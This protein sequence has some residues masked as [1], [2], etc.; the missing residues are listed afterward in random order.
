MP[1]GSLNQILAFS[2]P[3]NGSF[4]SATFVISCR[5]SGSKKKLLTLLSL[6]TYSP[7]AAPRISPSPVA[8]HRTTRALASNLSASAIPLH[9]AVS[10]SPASASATPKIAPPRLVDL[11]GYSLLLLAERSPPSFGFPAATAPAWPPITSARRHPTLDAPAPRFG[12]RLPVQRMS[13]PRRHRRYHPRHPHHHPL[14]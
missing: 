2:T 14:L 11:G 12:R 4:F 9:G 13:S 5:S 6:S 8:C 10:S 7:P 1:V 3:S